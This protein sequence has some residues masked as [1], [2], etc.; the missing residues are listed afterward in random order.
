MGSQLLEA[1]VTGVLVVVIWA[2]SLFLWIGVP[3]GGLWLAGEV[4]KTAEMF[5]FVVL[6]GIPLAMIAVGLVLY[7][8]HALYERIRPGGPTAPA[9]PSWLNAAS[10]ERPSLRRLRGGRSLLDIAMA[11]SVVAALVLLLVWFFFFAE[12]IPVSGR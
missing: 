5:L 1:L 11:V 7:R 8:V 4:T 10:E 2:G 6:G 3:L 9:R 12:L